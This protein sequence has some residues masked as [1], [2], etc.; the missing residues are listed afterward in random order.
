MFLCNEFPDHVTPCIFSTTFLPFRPT[1]LLKSS[2]KAKNLL[3]LRIKEGCPLEKI[4][5]IYETCPFMDIKYSLFFCDSFDVFEYLLSLGVDLFTRLDE[6]TVFDEWI[7]TRRNYHLFLLHFEKLSSSEIESLNL[8]NSSIFYENLEIFTL[9]INDER[10]IIDNALFYACALKDKYIFIKM[11]L[12]SPKCSSL[13]IN[14][15]YH[16]F[17]YT[18]LHYAFNS[19][20]ESLF[21][22]IQLLLDSGVDYRALDSFGR[23][24]SSILNQSR[25][26]ANIQYFILQLGNHIRKSAT[27]ALP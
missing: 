16:P 1:M 13:L 8:L 22:I 3:L 20:S 7:R 19:G 14:A 21:Q 10:V 26:T 23:S 6:M 17:N 27:P 9:L 11:M 15:Q 24:Y 5:K 18:L 12:E 25:N 4:K 2:I